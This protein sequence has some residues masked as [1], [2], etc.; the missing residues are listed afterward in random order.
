M[1]REKAV[2]LR[3]KDGD[4]SAPK[5]VAKGTGS[6]AESIIEL[7]RSNGIPVREDTELVELLCAIELYHEIPVELYRAVAEVL[8]FLYGLGQKEVSGYQKR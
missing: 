1:K 2:A 4:D 5:V 7:A 6:V 8:A 3:Y